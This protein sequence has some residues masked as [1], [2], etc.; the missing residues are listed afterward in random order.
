MGKSR[1]HIG[2]R[3]F[4]TLLAAGPLAAL[5]P[6]GAGVYGQTHLRKAAYAADVGILWDAIT[7]R[8]EGAIDET[9]D[10]A[11]GHYAVRAVGE[12]DGIANRLESSGRLRG[13]RWAPERAT[14]WFNVRGRE[15][16]SEITYDW[17]ARK[18]H[19]RFRGETFLL[20]RL[21]VVE[22]TLAIP[23]GHQVDDVISAVLN[24][25]DGHW[26]AEPDGTLR[27]HVV[28]RRKREGEGPDDVDVHQRAELVPFELK[29]G[30]D[31]ETGKPAASFDMTRFSSWA[32]QGKPG[33]I[34]FDAAGRPEL[35]VSSLILGTTVTIRLREA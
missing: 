19:Y 10:R 29:V 12:G 35:I 6:R 24:Y 7:L 25:A 15:S 30:R 26:K 11:A 5:L 14:A 8:L 21:R 31:P 16:R 17:P 18:I 27:T 34:L 9:I 3:R 23:E 20:R 32:R 4:L 2:R 28:R 22:D 1:E 13:G 33:R